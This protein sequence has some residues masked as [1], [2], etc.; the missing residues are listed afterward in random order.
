MSNERG[1]MLHNLETWWNLSNL[2]C[3]TLHGGL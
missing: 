3:K 2:F 1:P